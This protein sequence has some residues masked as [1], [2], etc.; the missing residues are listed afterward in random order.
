MNDALLSASDQKEALSRVYVR[1]VAARAGYVTTDRDFDRDGVDLGIEAGGNMRPKLDVQMKATENLGAPK[2][3][4]FHFPLKAG[5]YDKLRIDTQTPRILVVLDLPKDSSQWMTVTE[6][7]LVLRRRAFWLNLR[8]CDEK[9]NQSSVTV[10]I[11]RG[12]LFNV[13]SLHRLMQQSRNG[14]IQ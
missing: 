6:E 2:G 4:H 7:S 3:E 11:P 12:N 14:R 9:S 1:A 10:Q 5:N 13:D 8:G